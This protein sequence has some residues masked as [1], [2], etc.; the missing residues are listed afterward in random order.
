MAPRR[1][2]SFSNSFSFSFSVFP[3]SF[4][5]FA[6]IPQINSNHFQKF[7]KIQCNALTQQENYFF[8]TGTRFSKS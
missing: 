5:Q 3:I 4:I 1:P 6:K 8:R 2:F 7:S